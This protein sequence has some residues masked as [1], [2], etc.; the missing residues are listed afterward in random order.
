[1]KNILVLFFLITFSRNLLSQ[2]SGH[3]DIG[4]E[5]E[6]TVETNSDLKR[7]NHPYFK[8]VFFDKISSNPLKIILFK[9]NKKIK[10]GELSIRNKLYESLTESEFKYII[11]S[12]IPKN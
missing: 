5:K 3:I 10:S 6:M 9:S 1:M 11:E 8:G 7:I 12:K 2:T 4:W